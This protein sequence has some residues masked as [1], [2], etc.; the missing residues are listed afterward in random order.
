M[1]FRIIHACA[2]YG[3]QGILAADLFAAIVELSFIG[4]FS[5]HGSEP[6][7][8]SG[9]KG[10]VQNA[11]DNQQIQQGLGNQP[12]FGYQNGKTTIVGANLNKAKRC[13]IGVLFITVLLGPVEVIDG[14]KITLACVG[15]GNRGISDVDVAMFDHSSLGHFLSWQ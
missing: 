15:H 11:G 9:T 7:Q 4:L 14:F 8:F 10:A 6:L 5:T 2:E 13:P 1:H 12:C 3:N